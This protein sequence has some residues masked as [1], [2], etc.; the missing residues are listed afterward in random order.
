MTMKRVL[1][2]EEEAKVELIQYK[3]PLV[4]AGYMVDIASDATEASQLLKEKSY[5]VLVFDLIFPHG[6]GYE[7]G[8]FYIGLDLMKRLLGKKITTKR[9]YSPEDVMVFTAVTDELIH[10][11]IKELGVDVILTKHL[12]RLTA[13]KEKIDEVIEAKGKIE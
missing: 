13:L 6:A 11:Q 9:E 2:I 10:N 8:E 4:R 1:W 3:K 5:D 12:N 7:T